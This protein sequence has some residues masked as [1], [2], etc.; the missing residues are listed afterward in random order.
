H[1]EMIG[2]DASPSSN[3]MSVPLGNYFLE[4]KK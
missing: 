2:L 1:D 3:K 4:E